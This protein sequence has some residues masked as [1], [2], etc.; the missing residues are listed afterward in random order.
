MGPADD[1]A[2]TAAASGLFPKYGTRL[3]GPS[4]RELL[5]ERLEEGATPEAKT[6]SEQRKKAAEATG[7]GADVLGDFLNSS[8]GKSL[9]RELVRGVFDLLKKR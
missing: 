1:V 5:A 7:G 3:D 4:A 8:T 6:T 2:G 9:Q